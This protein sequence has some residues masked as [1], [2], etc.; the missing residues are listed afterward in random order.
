MV[1]KNELK[2]EHYSESEY[3]LLARNI[4]HHLLVFVRNCEH[5]HIFK[6]Q[7]EDFFFSQL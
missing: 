7:T 2:P 6:A 4:E 5:Y 1:Y 3:Q